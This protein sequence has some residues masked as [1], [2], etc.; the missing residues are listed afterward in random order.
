VAK[1]GSVIYGGSVYGVAPR[2]EYSV[3]PM[4][5][6]V[7]NFTEVYL[8]WQPPTGTFSQ[9]RLVRNQVGFPETEED[10]VIVWQQTLTPVQI[11]EGVTAIDVSTVSYRDG[12]DNETTVQAIKPG[13]Q[14]Y[15]TIFLFTAD[16]VWVKAGSISDIVP[17]DHNSLSKAMDFLPKIYTSAD[18]SPMSEVDTSSSLYG[19]MGG[20]G[21]TYDEMLTYTD[22]IQPSHSA[23]Q[24]PIELIPMQT[25]GLGL[26]PEPGIPVKN[27]KKLVR[28]AYYMYSR[29][30]THTAVQTYVEALTNY[31]ATI[32]TS[33]NL[34]LSVQDSTFYNSVGN[35]T[36]TNGILTASTDQVPSTSVTTTINGITINPVIDTTYSCK[37]VAS[38]SGSMKLGLTNPITTGA[39]VTPGT[40][41]TLSAQVKSPT[42]AGTI[43]PAIYFYDLTG[44]LIG[45]A[46]S[47][48]AHSATSSWSVASVTATSPSS[49]Y[50]SIATLGTITPGTGYTNGTYTG[51]TLTT[52]SGTAPSVSPIATIVVSGNQVASVTLTANGAG[53]DTTTVLTAPASSIGGT[54]S[55][56]SVPVASITSYTSGGTYAGIAFS[57]SASGTYYVDMVCLQ[58]GSS[59]SYDEARAVDVFVSPNKTNFDK[60]PSFE[61]FSAGAFPG[62]TASGSVTLS[63]ST[64]VTPL[65]SSGTHSAKVVGTTAWSLT[66]D[67]APVTPGVYYTASIFAKSS[68]P[69]HITMNTRNSGGTIQDTYTAVIPGNFTTTISGSSGAS[70][71]TVADA[72]GVSIGQSVSGTGIGSNAVVTLVSG[73]TITLSVANTGTVS[74]TGTFSEPW[75]RYSATFPVPVS[76]TATT[77][78]TVISSPT[79][80]TTYLDCAQLEQSP[81]VT[82][83]FDGSLP[84]YYGAVWAGT[85]NDSYSYLYYGKP[86][87]LP[88]LGSTLSNWLTN[89]TFWR[90]RSYAGVEYT[91]LLP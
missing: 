46:H 55:G 11:A 38:A 69:L 73:T 68:A 23:L 84:T 63:Q 16:K 2:I 29:K 36:A 91:N 76:T 34:L 54:G 66:S 8:T 85:A 30:G 40:T 71:I 42:S 12:E 49:A 1:Y 44:T 74:G 20:I 27:Q 41:Y 17:G 9:I 70:T 56:F 31:P 67:T 13:G 39:P 64:D 83:Y 50:S 3:E 86:L 77:I 25:L 21:F 48:T 82:E 52:L 37:V 5:I 72:S 4:T 22:L 89:N 75:E 81:V 24:T 47:G 62:W 7:I 14:V 53:V 32:T 45:S 6:E 43:T 19:F 87:K 33:Q 57:W 61:L 59:V 60:N 88:R 58:S 26:A 28:E 65:A 35:W 78:E 15:Y 51:V 90:I 18:Q 10:G 79:A 80:S